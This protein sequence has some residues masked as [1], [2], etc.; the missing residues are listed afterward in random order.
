MRELIEILIDHLKNRRD[1]L[2][3]QYKSEF[4]KNTNRI[5]NPDVQRYKNGHRTTIEFLKYMDKEIKDLEG[6]L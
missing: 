2:K 6:L 4:L 5:F 1:Q 3:N